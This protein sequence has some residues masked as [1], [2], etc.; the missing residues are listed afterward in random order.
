MAAFKQHPRYAP[1]T[2]CHIDGAMAWCIFDGD[3]IF[4]ANVWVHPDKRG[5][6]KG[7][8]IMSAIN[9]KYP[10]YEINTDYEIQ[11]QGFWEKMCAEGFVQTIHHTRI[12]FSWVNA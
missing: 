7:R 12:D 4:M 9:N 3:K 2:I 11:S 8:E 6:G 5:Q 1:V 10:T